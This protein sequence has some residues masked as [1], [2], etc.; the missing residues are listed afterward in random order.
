MSPPVSFLVPSYALHPE[1]LIDLDDWADNPYLA[2]ARSA[3]AAIRVAFG[4]RILDGSVRTLDAR[5]RGVV[6]DSAFAVLVRELSRATAGLALTGRSVP[7]APRA[8]FVEAVRS[9]WPL[10]V[11]HEAAELHELVELFP[12]DIDAIAPADP[13]ERAVLL[14]EVEALPGPVELISDAQTPL[15][16]VPLIVAGMRVVAQLAALGAAD[17][18]RTAPIGLALVRGARA[19]LLEN[20]RLLT[21]VPGLKV[22]ARLVPR[23]RR[24]DAFE[25]EKRRIER[26]QHHKAKLHEAE[27]F[28]ADD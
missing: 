9:R 22:P 1:V 16:L 21:L 17:A 15:E 20:A 10:V 25:L 2:R 6:N 27:A 24:L 8:D 14:T 5:I 28:F 3:G 23:A 4:E 26:R 7:A 12:A 19:D 13:I 11:A 18:N